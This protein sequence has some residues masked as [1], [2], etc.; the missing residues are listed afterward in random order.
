MR[1]NLL[2]IT[3][4]AIVVLGGGTLALR[5]FPSLLLQLKQAA[6]DN[7]PGAST[8]LNV[9]NDRTSS[10]FTGEPLTGPLG[11][12][13][14]VLAAGEVAALTNNERTARNLPA[15]QINTA[16]TKAAQ[17]KADDMFTRQY[18]AHIAPD[19]TDPAKL[20]NSVGYA[21][22]LVGENL[23]LGNFGTDE[24]LIA[25][26]MNSAGH[27]ANILKPGYTEIGVATV[28]GTYKGQTT[29]MAVQEFGTPQSVCPAPNESEKAQVDTLNA[30]LTTLK[31][32]LE[33]RKSELEAMNRHNQ[34]YNEKASAYNALI[35]QY[36]TLLE[37]LKNLI[38]AYNAEV[39][40][41]NVCI[42]S[43]I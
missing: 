13:A 25:A 29:W 21:F 8:L 30:E 18:F 3:L 23:A 5:A 36:N 27:R 6:N 9:S 35:D 28:P 38:N 37:Q 24:K 20:A 40:T 19:G 41:Y 17:Q 22:L 4:L 26:W 33:Q 2:I 42:K 11:E 32:E 7:L 31:T 34:A 14:T 10:V 12:Q 16:L 15:L 43:Y 1:K 39:G